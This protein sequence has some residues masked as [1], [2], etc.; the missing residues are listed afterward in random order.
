MGTWTRRGVLAGT[1]LAAVAGTTAAS[2]S[3]AVESLSP[4]DFTFVSMPDF[5]NADVADLTGLDTWDGGMNS[6][7]Q[8]WQL[9]IDTCLL[10]VQSHNPDAVF[11][12]GDQ[13]EGRWNVDS[14]SRALFGPVSSG[15]DEASLAQCRQAIS[16]AGDT[17]YSFYRDLFASR[18]LKV[19]AGIGDHEIL[20]DRGGP[21]S[22]RW[23]PTGFQNGE[24]DN[25]YHLVGHAKQVW[26]DHFT[27]N[28]RGKPRYKHRPKGSQ[29]EFTAYRQSFGGVL[30]LIT[31]DVFHMTGRGVRLGVFEEQMAWM[32]REIRKA[33]RKGHTVVV[34]GHV[35]AVGP[36][37]RFATGNLHMQGPPAQ[38]FW[39]ALRKAGA[40]FYFCGE[41]HDAS[42]NQPKQRDPVQV[43][44]GCTYRYGFSYLVG[45]VWEGRK[46]RLEYVE[47]PQLIQSAEAGIWC[48]DGTK[49]APRRVH[50]G[51]PL[52]RGALEW[53]NGV[54]LSRTDKLGPFDPD[55]DR[56]G[57]QKPRTGPLSAV[58][59]G[60][61][62]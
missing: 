6:L 20:D 15:I 53:N 24:P 54:I 4:P 17:Y 11:V 61:L 57:W 58:Q 1:G 35:P 48:T 16:R 18:D 37:R 62:S 33:K 44:H 47:I 26:A 45:K 7:N 52:V 23:S 29:H 5:L 34:Q 22:N 46:V 28:N 19:F 38:D 3:G 13:V 36:Y 39:R 32:K 49:I 60:T 27:R 10:A 25:R 14:D 31:V 42:V 56:K 50:Y 9:A 55:D 12:A 21:L 2:M 51:V 40:D 8:W 30:T 59:G 41:V 43:S